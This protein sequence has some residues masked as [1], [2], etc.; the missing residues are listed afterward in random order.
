MDKARVKIKAVLWEAQELPS[1]C[2]VSFLLTLL[3]G[4]KTSES[5]PMT[6]LNAAVFHPVTVKCAL[7]CFNVHIYMYVYMGMHA[8]VYMHKYKIILIIILSTC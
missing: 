3:S 1:S 8:Y 7:S 4:S 5:I 6:R 2:S